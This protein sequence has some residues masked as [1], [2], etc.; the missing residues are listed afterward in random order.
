MNGKRI[1][2]IT[3]HRS[4]VSN[5]HSISG[6]IYIRVGST[7]QRLEGQSIVEFLRNRQI[8]LFEEGTDQ[9]AEISDL[10]KEKMGKYLRARKNPDFLDT[11]SVEDFLKS[12]KLLAVQSGIKNAALIFFAKDPQK[13][14]P[15]AQIKLVRFDGIEPV[16][17]IAYE[18]AKGDP[19]EMIKQ[20]MN[21][22]GRFLSRE[23][24]IKGAKREEIPLLPEDAIREAIVNA[25]A[26]RDYFNKNEIQLSIFNDRI[27]LTNPG[28]LPEGMDKTLLGS[29]SV[30]RNPL[31]YQFLKDY[32]YMEGIGSGISRMRDSLRDA[33]LSDPEF[34]LSKEFFRIVLRVASPHGDKTALNARQ[35]K[36]IE[37]LKENRRIKS[38]DYA[39]INKVSVPSAVS[40][41]NALQKLGIVKNV[42]KHRGTYY[43]L[44]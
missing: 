18:E 44:K 14:F 3:V 6:V 28:G 35:L 15:Y 32:G 37:F 8:L 31:V 33:S 16:K 21:F 19:V 7:T 38:R 22:V 43:V 39:K 13:F 4:D 24:V 36:G 11:H 20:S 27:E 9:K 42:G 17:V 29:F 1:A 10:D 26:H 12:K 40:D 30:Q 34:I 2:Q 23:F 41:L 5:F 25:V